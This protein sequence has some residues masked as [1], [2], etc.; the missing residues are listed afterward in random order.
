FL[1]A[2][3]VELERVIAGDQ[4]ALIEDVIDVLLANRLPDMQADKD[5]PLD[6]PVIGGRALGADFNDAHP[7]TVAVAE[8][9]E[10]RGTR[11]FQL[12]PENVPAPGRYGFLA[13]GAFAAV[14]GGRLCASDSQRLGLIGA[15][16]LD[17]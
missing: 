5:V 15:S 2:D 12:Q 6:D 13:R 16:Q 7:A 8:G 17:V 9:L 14:G 11:F 4:V 1:A 10:L 3:H